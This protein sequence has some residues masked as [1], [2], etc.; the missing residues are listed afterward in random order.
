M[1]L[2]MKVVVVKYFHKRDKKQ[3]SYKNKKYHDKKFTE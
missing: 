2:N 3:N 1:D